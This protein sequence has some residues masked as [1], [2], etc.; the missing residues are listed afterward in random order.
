MYNPDVF[1]WRNKEIQRET[2]QIAVRVE[3]N[4][5]LARRQIERAEKLLLQLER[6]N[7]QPL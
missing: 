5:I 6:F 2:A 1:Y 3:F 7:R 4:V